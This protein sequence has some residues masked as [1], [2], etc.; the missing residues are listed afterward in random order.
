M[1]VFILVNIYMTDKVADA[2]TILFIVIIKHI[3]L[4]LTVYML[5]HD[6]MVFP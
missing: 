1:I 3:V 2:N 5:G 4:I 6:L